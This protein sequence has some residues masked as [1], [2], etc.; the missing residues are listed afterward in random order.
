PQRAIR[1]SKS[2]LPTHSTSHPLTSFIAF[3]PWH[4]ASSRFV[5]LGDLSW[6]RGTTRRS[7]DYFFSSLAWFFPSRLGTLEL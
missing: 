2:G 1:Q 4:S 5:T 6:L 3:S 7:A